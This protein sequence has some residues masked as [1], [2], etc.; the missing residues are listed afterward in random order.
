MAQNQDPIARFKR[1]YAKALKK[2]P[3]DATACIL[4]TADPEGRPSAR[5]V[6][7]KSVD[8]RGFVIYTNGTSRKGREL[9]ENPRAS[10]VFHWQALDQQIRV[11][12]RVEQ[13][14]EEESDAYF[15]SRVRGS[16]L[17]AWASAQ[18]QPMSGRTELIA[19]YLRTK[20]K[21][22]GRKVPRPPHWGGYRII[23]D[24]IEFWHRHTFRLHD[25][26]EYTLVNGQ[27]EMTML[28]P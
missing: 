12:G 7:L 20:M 14:A 27:W 10:L 25:R 18:S 11:E 26:F 5:V 17:G 23:P 28:Y 15:A 19:K 1:V 24:R 16:Q 22:A 8:E 21:Y 4:A 13:V 2:E 6:L 3:F 9:G